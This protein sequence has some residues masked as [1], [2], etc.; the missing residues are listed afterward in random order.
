MSQEA[1]WDQ[2]LAGDTKAFEIIYKTYIQELFVYGCHFTSDEEMVKDSIQDVFFNLLNSRKQLKKTDNIKPYLLVSL[3]KGIL[4]K[5]TKSNKVLILN[6][7]SLPF[8]YTLSTK[9]HLQEND[10]KQRKLLQQALNKLTDRQREAIFLRFV[11][12]CSYDELAETLDIGYQ[13]SRNLI[14]RGMKKLR[15]NIDKESLFLFYHFFNRM[16]LLSFDY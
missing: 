9:E 4:R 8:L 7:E 16:K 6:V 13:E 3:K 10:A 15:A 1:L 11:S 5:L 12:D 14:Y 2:F